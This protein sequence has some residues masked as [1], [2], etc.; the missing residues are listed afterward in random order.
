MIPPRGGAAH[1]L[2]TS[3]SDECNHGAREPNTQSQKSAAK[4]ETVTAKELMDFSQQDVDVFGEDYNH[5]EQDADASSSTSSSASSSASSGSS[6][7]SSGS[8][9]SNGGDRAETSSGGEEE[10]GEEAGNV[11]SDN[12]RY[13]HNDLFGEE[14]DEEK[15]LFGSDHE[16]YC[17]NRSISSL[18]L[19]VLPA[20]CNANN[21]RG[22]GFGRGHWNDRGAGI[23]PCPNYA[24]GMDM[25]TAQNLQMVAMM[26]DFPA[27]LLAIVEGGEVY[28]DDRSL[29]VT[30]LEFSYIETTVFV[31][32]YWKFFKWLATEDVGADLNEGFDTFI[33]EKGNFVFY[34]KPELRS[35]AF[36]DLFACIR[37]KNIPLHNMHSVRNG[38]VFL[39]VHKLPE[40]PKSELDLQRCY[41]GYCIKILA[42]E[43]PNRGCGEWKNHVDANVEYCS[44]IKTKLGPHCILMGTEMDCCDAMDDGRKFYMELKTSRVIQSFLEGVPYIVF[45]FRD[46]AG[47]LVRTEQLRTKDITHRV[48]VKN[49]WQGAVWLAFADEVLRWLYGTVKENEGYILQFAPSFIRLELLQAQSCPD[50]ITNHVEQNCSH[51]TLLN[52]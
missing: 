25:G 40:R 35:E 18:H 33:D 11:R 30:S 19:P 23:L 22:G 49:Y 14:E 47:H 50:A 37:D 15:D 43:D 42:T 5:R 36:G 21:L 51:S 4:V 13:N 26:N 41:W 1:K 10:N 9:S 38:V 3:D 45:G 52:T 34:S 29:M 17:K 2:Q 12:Y 20:I 48:K 16:D 46:G 31:P 7:S 44:A 24:Q 6:S 28:F 27:N 39:D 8:S 32:H